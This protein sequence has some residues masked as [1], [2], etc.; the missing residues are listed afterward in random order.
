MAHRLGTAR[1]ISQIGKGGLMRSDKGLLLA[2]VTLAGFAL[3][4]PAQAQEA[5]EHDAESAVGVADIIVTAQRRSQSLLEVP[6]SITALSG[7]TLNDAGIKQLT[8]LQFVTPGYLPSDV[9]GYT[10]IYIRGVGNS[11]FVGADPSVATFIDDVPRIYGSMVNNMVDVERVEVLKGAQ[12]GLYG[13]NATGGVV[14]IVTRKPQVDAMSANFQLSYGEKNTFRAAGFVNLPIADTLAVALSGER[15]VH[16]PYIR[17]INSPAPYTAAM[18]SGGSALGNAQ[19]TADVLNSGHAPLRGY[20]NEDFFALSGKLLFQP[21]SNLS[22]TLAGDYSRKNDSGGSQTYLQTPELVQSVIAGYLG[23]FTGANPQLPP[24][25]LIPITKKFTTSQGT[26]SQVDLEDYGGSL[27]A[28]LSLD[29][30]ELTSISAYRQQESLFYG[31]NAGGTVRFLEA[32]VN[33]HKHYYYQEL[34]AVSTGSGPFNFIAGASLLKNSF[35]GEVELNILPPLVEGQALANTSYKVTNWSAYAQGTYDFTDR[36]SLTA[37]G[38]YIHE[39]N[40]ASFTLPAAPDFTISEEK[41]LPAATLSY[42]LASG[43]NAYLRWARGFKAG[44]VT[45]VAPPTLF[46]NPEVGSIFK[47]ETVDTFEAGIRTSL[48]DRNV[49]FTAA[50]FY[51]DYKNLQVAAHGNAAHPEILSAVV[52]AGSARTWGFEAGVTW[53]VAEP[54]TLTASGGYLN[55]KY[56]EFKLTDGSVLEPFDLSGGRMINAPKLQLSFTG[57]LD[58]PL[59]DR[60]SLIGNVLVS[61]VGKVIWIQSGLP[62][63]LPPSFDPGYWLTNAKL[64]VRVDDRFDVSVF[65]NNLFNAAYTTGGNSAASSG[66][67]LNWGNPRIVGVQLGFNF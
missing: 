58:Q 36:L 37:S 18:F 9:T 32:V 39:K 43:G 44:G 42:K 14:N 5:Q 65:A 51:N 53:R 50:A 47:G 64:G 26:P 29:N 10:Q 45:P 24:G 13:R 56:K 35:R 27:T 40:R 7:E 59:S 67:T 23:L 21:S 66:T 60:V 49:Q 31:D 20:N 22:F 1:N 55:A 46:V 33:N 8:D 19:Q 61:H 17:N 63:V 3:T 41:F 30:V 54:L 2:S 4:I 62:G 11:I 15:R 52:N 16:D 25:F 12:G 38:R 28:V 34:R 48:F 57:N 6:L